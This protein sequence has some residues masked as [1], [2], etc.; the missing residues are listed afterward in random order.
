MAKKLKPSTIAFG[1]AGALLLFGLMRKAPAATSAPASG[2][3][4]PAPEPHET[5]E[6]YQDRLNAWSLETGEM[7]PTMAG[8]GGG[9]YGTTDWPRTGGEWYR[10]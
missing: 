9:L 4:L 1:I 5:S 7:V 8:Y 3:G 2:G 6:S 10:Y